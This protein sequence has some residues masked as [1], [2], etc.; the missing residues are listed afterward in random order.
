MMLTKSQKR[1]FCP[2]KLF[3]PWKKRECKSHDER[4][5]EHLANGHKN[6]MFIT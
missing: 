2:S 5:C 4:G 6:Q 3:A 1:Y